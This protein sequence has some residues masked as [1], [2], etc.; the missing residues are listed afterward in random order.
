[1]GSDLHMEN[2][3]LTC[4]LTLIFLFVPRTPLRRKEN[5]SESAGQLR[6]FNYR[7]LMIIFNRRVKNGVES[8]E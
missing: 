8:D 7:D 3:G 4:I 1:M 5:S 6:S 2:W